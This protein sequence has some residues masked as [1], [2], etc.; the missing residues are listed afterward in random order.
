MKY[1]QLLEQ[2]KIYLDKNP[3][4]VDTPVSIHIFTSGAKW[5]ADQLNATTSFNSAIHFGWY[6]VL[7]YSVC[8]LAFFAAAISLWHINIFLLPLAILVFYFFEVHFLFLFPLLIDNVKQPL[9]KSI[10][11][12][13]ATGIL[14]CMAT[15]IPI[16]IFMLAGVLNL[17]APFKNWHIGSLAILTWYKN[18]IRNRL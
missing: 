15:V 2:S 11:L 4:Y 13:Y 9:L 8:V 1:R 18:D 12:S 6:G 16:S 3:A 5:M 10:Q 7:K 17:K 14:T